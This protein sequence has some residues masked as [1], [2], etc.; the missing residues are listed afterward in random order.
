MNHSLI[1]CVNTLRSIRPGGAHRIATVLREEGWDVEVIDWST[2]WTLDELKE[3]AK[4]RI[5]SNTVFCGFSSF[6]QHWDNHIEEF[7]IW[8]KQT[9]P[10]V[11]L[12]VGGSRIPGIVSKS[13]DYFIT[14]H[15]E[16]AMLELVKEL[17]G[18]STNHIKYDPAYF[19]TAKVITANTFYPATPMRRAGIIYEDRDFIQPNEF[20]TTEFSRGCK[21]K[22]AFCSYPFLGIKEDTTRDTDDFIYQMENAY[23]RFGVTHYN[24]V[25]ETFNDRTDKIIKFADAVEKL[26]FSP[27]L[28]G[29]IRADLLV[30]RRGDWEHLSRMRFLGQFYGI[31][32]TNIATVKSV[33]KGMNPDRLLS[34]ILEARDYFTSVSNNQYRGTISLIAGLPH[35]TIESLQKTMQWLID[36]WQGQAF[37]MTPMLIEPDD[38]YAGASEISLDWKKYGYKK[39]EEPPSSKE[40][41]SHFYQLGMNWENDFMNFDQAYTIADT[42][43]KESTLKYNFTRTGFD[44]DRLVLRM[45][46]SEALTVNLNNYNKLTFDL[47]NELLKKYIDKKLS[48]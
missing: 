25:D 28:N 32:S 43:I 34:G 41:M 30:S 22:C 37:L 14:G 1:F 5:N 6:F 9:Y 2:Y 23:D 18:N 39:R 46:L 7:V 27:W 36:N 4:L 38:M 44:L 20:L 35:E 33:G 47:E 19:G 24:V 48:L 29:F 16:Y 42:F 8:L 21:F 40:A 45:S 3:L 12:I 15:A 13:I 11:K 31:E 10:Q 17:T 26:S